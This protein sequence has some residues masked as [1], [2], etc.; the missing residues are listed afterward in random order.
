MDPRLKESCR[1]LV[2]VF[3]FFFSWL[4]LV[5]IQ[6]LLVGSALVRTGDVPS[7]DNLALADEEERTSK[8]R[9]DICVS[10]SLESFLIEFQNKKI[11]L[12]TNHFLFAFIVHWCKL[13]KI[14]RGTAAMAWSCCR[15]T[16]DVDSRHETRDME[17]FR[18][19][20]FEHFERYLR[21]EEEEEKF[22]LGLKVFGTY[23]HGI[24]WKTCKNSRGSEWVT[25]VKES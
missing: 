24:L 5:F 7:L 19:L 25:Q 23:P 12:C 2:S 14:L 18:T 17:G 22:Y 11:F 8:H 4:C 1:Y 15:P 16:C 20:G 21:K 6:F 9:W 13:C 3:L 10:F